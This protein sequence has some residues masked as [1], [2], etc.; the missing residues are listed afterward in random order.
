M[1]VYAPKVNKTFFV[2]G[3]TTNAEEKHL[4][5]MTSVFDHHTG[6]VSKPTVVCDKENVIDPHDNPSMM[7]DNKGFIHVFVSGR[8]NV[9]KGL[10]F[11]KSN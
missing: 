9:R 10:K 5:A 7:I 4:L 3:G 2:F 1:A 11:E 6:M 8:G